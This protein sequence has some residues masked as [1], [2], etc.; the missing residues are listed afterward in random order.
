MTRICVATSDGRSYY[1][2][3]S[4]LRNAGVIFTSMLPEQVGEECG[5]VLTTQA[6]ASL[7]GDR[8][9]A[10]EQL[11]DD[12]GVVKGQILSRLAGGKGTLLVGIDPGVRMGVAV[13]YGEVRLAVRTLN[14]RERLFDMVAD[15]VELVRHRKSTVKIG[16]GNPVLADSLAAL[17]TRR[18]PGTEV[19]IVDETGTSIRSKHIKGLLKDEGAATRIAFRKGSRHGA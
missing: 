15:F 5:L 16:N 2:L 4:R 1:T 14:S 13:Y 18:L 11:D 17:L 9:L 19:E 3:V 6:E 8:A 7:F 10:L 12:P